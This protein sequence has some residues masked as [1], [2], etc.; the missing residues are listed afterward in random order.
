MPHLVDI[1]SAPAN[2]KME[3]IELSE[4]N[5]MKSLFNSKNDP[6][7]IWKNAIGYPRLC[8]H[9]QKM[10][11]CFPTAYCCESTFS[12]TQPTMQ[13]R[14]RKDPVRATVRAL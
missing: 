4:D 10:L 9:A 8:H 5:I 12:Y 3:L 7:E 14:A 2:L 6:L 13:C 11:S 1:S